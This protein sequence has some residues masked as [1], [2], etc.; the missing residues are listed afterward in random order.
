[1][2]QVDWPFW[3]AMRTVKLWEACALII[4]LDPD[5]LKGHPQSWMNGPGAGPM[6]D[7]R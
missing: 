6:F 2:S 1:M 7:K 4:D 5:K 3:K